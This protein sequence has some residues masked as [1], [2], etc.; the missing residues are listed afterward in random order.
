MKFPVV[1]NFSTCQRT[2]E[3]RSKRSH[4]LNRKIVGDFEVQL[5]GQK[6]SSHRYTC[7]CTKRSTS[8]LRERISVHTARA[9]QI[10]QFLPEVEY[11]SHVW[12]ASPI[13][14]RQVSGSH[15]LPLSCVH[16]FVIAG[17]GNGVG[18]ETSLAR[19]ICFFMFC[20]VVFNRGMI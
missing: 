2:R 4:K 16:V 3:T 10:T 8:F 5:Y 12:S 7:C 19:L 15:F 1:P 9:A 11:L 17:G 18:K 14:A 13:E 20:G 6:T